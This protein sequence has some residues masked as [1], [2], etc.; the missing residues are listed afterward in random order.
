MLLTRGRIA[1]KYNSCGR[2]KNLSQ[3]NQKEM[4]QYKTEKRKEQEKMITDRQKKKI[5]RQGHISKEGKD[6]LMAWAAD[7]YLGQSF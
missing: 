3:S 6:L 1:E 5:E 2:S 7:S 4:R